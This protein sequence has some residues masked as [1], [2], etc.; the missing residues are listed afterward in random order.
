VETDHRAGWASETDAPVYGLASPQRLSPP[1]ITVN[2]LG[3]DYGNLVWQISADY[4]DDGLA[5]V[6]VHTILRRKA[7]SRGGDRWAESG[8]REAKGLVAADLGASAQLADIADRP[9]EATTLA[10][11]GTDLPAEKLVTARGDGWVLELETA[12]IG[13]VGFDP[14]R[15]TIARIDLASGT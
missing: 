8:V 9:W 1:R 13:L 2:R 12:V 7:I 15:D 5:P 10:L 14:G 11:D 6:T 4:R 3:P